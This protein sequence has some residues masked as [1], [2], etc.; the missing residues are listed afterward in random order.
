MEDDDFVKNQAKIGYEVVK[1]NSVV[2]RISD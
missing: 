2:N 1:I